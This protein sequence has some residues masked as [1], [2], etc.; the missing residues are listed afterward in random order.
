MNYKIYKILYHKIPKR[1]IMLLVFFMMLLSLSPTVIYP[2]L[3]RF[4]SQQSYQQFSS[5][6]S[7]S[8]F[9]SDT[10]LTKIGE[11]GWGPCYGIDLKGNHAYIGNGLMFQVLDI[12]DPSN[13][14]L[15]GEIYTGSLIRRIIVS[16]NFAYT[17]SP[18]RIIDISDPSHP[19]LVETVQLP[20]V[21][22]A[23]AIA[24][25]GNY[26]YIGDFYGFIFT[27]DV[28]NPYNPVILD[29]RM[30]ASGE[31]VR[32]IAVK[33]TVLYAVTY[34]SPG[35]NVYSISNPHSP[36]HIRLAGTGSS[37]GSSLAI[38]NQYLYLG[39]SGSFRIFDISNLS[40]PRFI[41]GITVSSPVRSISVADNIAYVI[42][43]TVGLTQVDI[44]DTSNIHITSEVKN[45]YSHPYDDPFGGQVGGAVRF[46]Y[47][48]LAGGTGLW[49]VNVEKKDIITPVSLYPTGWY[50][51]KIAVDSSNHAYL[52][53]LHGGL[54]ILDFSDPCS[55][56]L[57]GYYY[58]DEQVKDVAVANDLAYLLGSRDLQVLDVSNPASPKLMGR[59]SFN[60]SVATNPLGEFYFLCLDDSTV[61]AARKSKKLFAI[62][63]GQPSDP[64]IKSTFNLRNIPVGLSVSNGYLYVAV[65]DTGIHIINVT[66]PNRLNEEG[67]LI[68]SPLRGLD[69]EKNNL[70]VEGLQG[71]ALVRYD[72]ADPLNPILKYIINVPG[73][74]TT[75]VDIKAEEDFAYL[76]YNNK[77]IVADISNPDSGQIIFSENS[78]NFDIGFFHAV[79]VSN[80]IVLTGGLGMLLFKK[81]SASSLNC[82]VR[83]PKSFQLFQN[84]PNPFN[85]STVIKYQ[86]S[87][88][89]RVTLKI[90]DILGKEVETAVNSFQP[91]GDY[92][93]AFDASAL[94]S[95]VYFYALEVHTQDG[96]RSV[97]VKKME[98]LK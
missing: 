20:D 82:D 8:S 96:K 91:A 80:D 95:G 10:V 24:V 2:Q 19:V 13:P 88:S 5:G 56:E 85:Q 30:L 61:Y 14:T 36:Y 52:A 83:L 67:F 64:K 66:Y 51:N 6:K 16:G 98:S 59:V 38:H 11:W 26:V 71:A 58:D 34:D 31:I 32:S 42:Q 89:S 92:A 22:P 9:V 29:G 46:P 74:I 15:V 76:T 69:I 72:I 21:Y 93:V 50:V 44:S 45:P 54:K 86:L 40:D 53:E 37:P 12:S 60:D 84:Y 17:I 63:V 70:W 75:F 41:T 35:I 49:I 18:F 90:Y 55:P 94:S 65:F 28:T 33:D 23:T 25:N 1:K 97:L 48:Y 79:A 57:I 4:L 7:Y 77:F 43:D 78:D 3:G 27:V 68:S 39:T 81:T 47:A 87:A 62:D 73:G